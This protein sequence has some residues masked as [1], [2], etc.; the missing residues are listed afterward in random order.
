MY[1]LA[2]EGDK[3]WESEKGKHLILSLKI[4]YS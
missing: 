3:I 4:E 2:D 1:V